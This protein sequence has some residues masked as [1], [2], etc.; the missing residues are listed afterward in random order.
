M[1]DAVAF[2]GSIS[3]EALRE[4]YAACDVFALP[5]RKEGFG[6]VYLEAMTFGKACLGARAG[7]VPEVI[8]ER[9]GALAEYGNHSEITAALSDLARHPRNSALVR[10][11]ASRFDFPAFRQRLAAAL[12]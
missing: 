8:D 10:R 11:H 1:G 2:T 9:V 5:S 7:G 3:D 6:L 4:E 12:S